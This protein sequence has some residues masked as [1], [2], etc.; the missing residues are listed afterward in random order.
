MRQSKHGARIARVSRAIPSRVLFSHV[1]VFLNR[2]RFSHVRMFFDW[3]NVQKRATKS[4][5]LGHCLITGNL[6]VNSLSLLILK[7]GCDQP[8][9]VTVVFPNLKQ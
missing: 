7:I 6:V 5:T 8:V 3:S 2:V 9:K 4:D 1:R